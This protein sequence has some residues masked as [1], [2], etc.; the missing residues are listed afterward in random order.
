MKFE[1][2]KI[3]ACGCWIGV[4]QPNGADEN[5]EVVDVEN[6]AHVDEND[7]VVD[8]ENIANEFVMEPM[9]L[10]GHGADSA[11]EFWCAD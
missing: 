7:E 10:S 4:D 11:D 8:V 1:V 5:D 2:L 3:D 6:I 9:K